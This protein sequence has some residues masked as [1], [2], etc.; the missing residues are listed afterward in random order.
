MSEPPAP[1]AATTMAA[2]GTPTFVHLRTSGCSL[3][4]EVPAREQAAE[5][6]SLPRVVPPPV[7]LSGLES[8]RRYRVVPVILKLGKE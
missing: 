8:E 3:L 1:V 2:T 6:A 5:F 4:L 7:R